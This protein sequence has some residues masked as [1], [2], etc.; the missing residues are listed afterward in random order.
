[1]AVF[2]LGLGGACG[3]LEEPGR[4][5]RSSAGLSLPVDAMSA[6][7]TL[8]DDTGPWDANPGDTVPA[9]VRADVAD[10]VDANETAVDTVDDGDAEDVW[11]DVDGGDDADAD[12][13]TDDDADA[14]TDTDDD[15][16][17]AEDTDDDAQ[18]VAEDT[19]DDAD[20]AC[21]TCDDVP[22][23]TDA[24]AGCVGP[25]EGPP[26]VALDDQIACVVDA[27]CVLGGA[28]NDRGVCTPGGA[29][30]CHAPGFDPGAEDWPDLRS[31]SSVASFCA[32]HPGMGYTWVG[33]GDADCGTRVRCPCPPAAPP[34]AARRAGGRA[35]V[36][37]ACHPWCTDHTDRYSFWV[38]Q[39]NVGGTFGWGEHQG[40]GV[41]GYAYDWDARFWPNGVPKPAAP[42]NLRPALAARPWRDA[43]GDLWA[44]G[45]RVT[46]PAQFNMRTSNPGGETTADEPVSIAHA[47]DSAALC[48][49]PAALLNQRFF[50]H[51][52]TLAERVPTDG[53]YRRRGLIPM[54]LLAVNEVH[55]PPQGGALP[56]RPRDSALQTG[57]DAGTC[58]NVAKD[59]YCDAVCGNCSYVIPSAGAGG[60][61]APAEPG[62]QT[63]PGQMVRTWAG[64]PMRPQPR[65]GW[66]NAEGALA[67]RYV[68][69]SS[70]LNWMSWALGNW[71]DPFTHCYAPTAPYPTQA[72]FL[73]TG[74]RT[75]RITGM[76]GHNSNTDADSELAHFGACR[77]NPVRAAT[78]AFYN[79]LAGPCGR[80][81]RPL[82]TF[83][84]PEQWPC[85]DRTNTAMTWWGPTGGI[86]DVD[87]LAVGHVNP[88]GPPM[89]GGAPAPAAWA[90]LPKPVCVWHAAERVYGM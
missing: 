85:V 73:D 2:A 1:M 40:I 48:G 42:G 15:A 83:A 49:G 62:G 47:I 71:S 13:D 23:V 18:D 54:R 22:D 75:R 64:A 77:A 36:L 86:H 76:Y 74:A 72:S 10:D 16:D 57:R 69:G 31:D 58:L 39:Y 87:D 33:D 53:W 63:A 82:A 67:V 41:I 28:C 5:E 45:A 46:E 9:D 11:E 80:C 84:P 78:P 66:V 50:N 51:G 70:Y 26:S 12:V 55:A 79:S 61:F 14:D 38:T 60:A 35:F 89:A 81:G 43:R 8:D 90:A 6:D 52:R 56:S 21:D 29:A 88:N 19:T 3:E 44:V 25:S 17:V 7:A 59:G 34:C 32:R 4:L 20:D 65:N 68:G 30:D 27:D 37:G 24:D